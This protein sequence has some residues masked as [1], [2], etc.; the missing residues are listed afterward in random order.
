MKIKFKTKE[1]SLSDF[2][3]R[4]LLMSFNNNEKQEFQ[5]SLRLCFIDEG[6]KSITNEMNRELKDEREKVPFDV[7]ELTNWLYGGADKVKEKRFL[8]TGTLIFST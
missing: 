2:I 7:E 3:K 8:G 1:I 4:I 5:H 6:T